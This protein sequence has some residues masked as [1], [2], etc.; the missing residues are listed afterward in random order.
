[1]RRWRREARRSVRA[2]RTA[3]RRRA[4]GGP[5]TPTGARAARALARSGEMLAVFRR[6]TWRGCSRRK[7]A[8]GRTTALHRLG[9]RDPG[10]GGAARGARC[11]PARR[12]AASTMPSFT[13]LLSHRRKLQRSYPSGDLEQARAIRAC[14]LTGRSD[15]SAATHCRRTRAFRR[16]HQMRVSARPIVALVERHM[17][18]PDW[19][20]ASQRAAW[21]LGSRWL[22]QG[23]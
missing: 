2:A 21:C 6:V 16:A 7:S 10:D 11:L 14:L 4:M 1:L 19:L 13:T 8:S 3:T 9:R 20:D 12:R 17:V 18:A 15:L 22:E 5:R 23:A